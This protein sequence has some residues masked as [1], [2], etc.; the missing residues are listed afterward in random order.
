M[1][2][3]FHEPKELKNWAINLANVLGGQKV[4]KSAILVQLDT[5]KVNTL[6]DKFVTDYNESIELVKDIGEEE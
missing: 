1:A 3:I 5:V 2:N 6:V 4:D